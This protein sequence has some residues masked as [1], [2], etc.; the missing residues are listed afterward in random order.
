MKNLKFITAIFFILFLNSCSITQEELWGSKIDED[1]IVKDLLINEDGTQVI[2]VGKKYYYFLDD[3][4]KMVQK[5]F[6]WDGKE[7]LVM[8]TYIRARG[9]EVKLGI[10]FKAKVKDLSKKQI[11]FLEDL[12]GRKFTDNSGEKNISLP[13]LTLKGSRIKSDSDLIKNKTDNFISTGFVKK[14]YEEVSI[15]DP[16]P[17]Q[18]AGKILL[19]P[20]AVAADILLAPIYFIG[21]LGAG[22]GSK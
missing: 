7:K 8:D 5:L 4:K 17:P 1:E 22:V 16:T 2:K 18:I 21:I 6:L 12:D 20:F 10:N 15:E 9:A 13:H 3:E 11:E 19:T 14:E